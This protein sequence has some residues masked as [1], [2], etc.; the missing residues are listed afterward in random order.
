MP[1]VLKVRTSKLVALGLE[2]FF[3]HLFNQGCWMELH[4]G[5]AELCKILPDRFSIATPCKMASR[6]FSC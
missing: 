1:L 3:D 4:G 2:R 6:W 5:L